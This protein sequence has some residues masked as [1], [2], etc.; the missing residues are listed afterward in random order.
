MSATAEATREITG[1]E[2]FRAL[3]DSGTGDRHMRVVRR[4]IQEHKQTAMTDLVNAG[5]AP[6]DAKKTAAPLSGRELFDRLSR[7]ADD[8]GR[9]VL[10]DI[11]LR[12][13]ANILAGQ[14]PDV[15]SKVK[16]EDWD[17]EIDGPWDGRILPPPT[18][19]EIESRQLRRVP[20]VETMST[21][22]PP[23]VEP[24]PTGG[25][26]HQTLPIGTAPDPRGPAVGPKP[27]GKR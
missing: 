12:K 9:P 13:C 2:L 26:L 21:Q 7:L 24:K 15:G 25:A 20:Q 4:V 23:N 19:E 5:V 6:N 14:H 11:T 1:V 3:K 16:P 27:A 8:R 18:R 22:A 10:S 17:D